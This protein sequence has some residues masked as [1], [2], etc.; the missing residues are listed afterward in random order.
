LRSFQDPAYQPVNGEAE[1]IPQAGPLFLIPALR[2]D[3]VL[4][5]KGPDDET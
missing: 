3:Q 4:L 2:L 1:L 5:G